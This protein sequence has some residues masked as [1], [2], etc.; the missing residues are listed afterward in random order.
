VIEAGTVVIRN[1][2]IQAVGK[3]T[4]VPADARVWDMKGMTIYAGFIE[5]YL[6]LDTT[7][8]PVSTTD[9]DRDSHRSFTSGGIKFYGTPGAQTDMGDPGPG[10]PIARITPEFR[11]VEKLFAKRKRAGGAARSGF[12]GRPHRAGQRHHSR[13][14]RAGGA[15]G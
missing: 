11:A 15:G 2:L 3:D 6:V 1:G 5:P 14:Q 10:D 4:A 13:H 9:M 12:Y 8:A 7:N